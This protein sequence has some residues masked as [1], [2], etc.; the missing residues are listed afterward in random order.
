VVIGALPLEVLAS[1][2]QLEDV[3][4]AVHPTAETLAYVG[5]LAGRHASWRVAVLL[6]QQT[7]ADAAVI[8]ERAM[9][10]FRPDVALFVG[11]AG[12]IKDVSAGD[13]VASDTVHDVEYGKDTPTGYEVR[14]REFRGSHGLVQRA[15]FTAASTEWQQRIHE[16]DCAAP[17]STTPTVH[18]EPIACGTKVVQETKGEIYLRIR[19][20]A[21]RAVA[22]EMEGIGFSAAVDKA[23]GV[24]GL[25]IRGVS[26]MLKD[27]GDPFDL[28]RQRF[29][30]ARASAFAAQTLHDMQLRD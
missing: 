22:I 9:S 29:A 24:R 27:K 11:V 10:W 18:I 1:A 2:A 17:I 26:D 30:A 13:V 20:A 28:C 23:L 19:K 4:E 3:D 8:T 6:C 7:S 15:T 25:V 21:P 14:P 16:P 5:R 12:G